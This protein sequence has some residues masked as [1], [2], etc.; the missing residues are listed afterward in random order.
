MK[1][2]GLTSN[3]DGYLTKIENNQDVI[4][5]RTNSEV[6]IEVVDEPTLID[7]GVTPGMH[8]VVK[9]FD[10]LTIDSEEFVLILVDLPIKNK[11]TKYYFRPEQLKVT[12]L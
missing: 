2:L 6:I 12:R 8:G 5:L 11:R 3:T 7:A 4:V 1:S 10:V 9:G